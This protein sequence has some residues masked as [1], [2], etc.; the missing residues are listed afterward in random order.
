M[1]YKIV[2][3]F[4]E[5]KLKKNAFK[6]LNEFKE[7]W[8]P[9]I[10]FHCYYYNLDISNYS[11]PQADNI[12]YHKLENIEEYSTFVEENKK[13]NGTEDGAVQYTE[14]LDGL[15]AAPE[16][17]AITECAFEN[18]ESWLLWVDPMCLTV[19]DI[20]ISTLNNYFP[21]SVYNV[22]FVYT[23]ET[24]YLM[25]FNLERQTAVDIL[26]D[27]RGSYM[28]G[29]YINYRE[30][31]SAFILSRLVTIYTAHGMVV[32]EF[33][34]ME[35]LLININNKNSV[36][37][38]NSDGN[39]I[40]ELS[41][42][43]TTP[44]ILPSRY[45]QLADT[46]RFYEPKTILETGTWNGGRAIEM[47]LA[48][49]DRNDAIH[50]I[51]YDLF[52]DATTATDKE[53]FNAKPHNTMEAV[54]KRLDEFKEHIKKEKNKEFSYELHKGNVRDTLKKREEP[55]I[56]DFA[57]IGSG[58]SIKTV[59]HEFAMLSN[60]P[61][62]MG[63]HFFTK[64]D[65]EKTP[66]DKYQGM[67]VLFDSIATKKLHEEKTTDDGW[68]TF[69]EKSNVR[70]HVLPS[71]DKVLGGG[72]THLVVF[73]TD[74]SVADIPPE[75]KQVPIVVHPRDSVPKE[76]I[77]NNIVTN[78]TLIDKD[79]WVKKHPAHKNKA[80]IV[81][82]GPYLDYEELEKFIHDNPGCKVLSVKHALP[83]L[84]KNNIIPWGCIVL[85]PRPITGKS[86]H[87]IVRKDLF[88]KTDPSI[89]FFVASMTDPSV[90]K[91][92]IE[93]DTRMWGWHAFTDSLREEDEQ[94]KVIENQQVKLSQELGIPQGA[95]LITGGT[96]AA[97]RGIGMM[98]TMGFRDIHLFGFDCC[99][100]EPSNE[101]KTETTGDLEGGETPKPKYIQVN[102][103]D[104][105]Y[106]TTGELLAMAQDCEKVFNDPGLEGVLSFHGKDTMVADLWKIK[107]KQEIRPQFK[108]YYDV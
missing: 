25:A 23:P 86:T 108:G 65:D 55:F 43:E 53:E 56:A 46:I 21:D 27:W 49:F 30:W 103:T 37:V 87:N 85:D 44:D 75:L 92:L 3:C 79:K 16:V 82:A 12:K 90:T 6:L 29:E 68:T 26:G 45:K 24:S 52:E 78:L 15:S 5:K 22:D 99:R 38:R 83:G 106:W 95:T 61:V 88:E 36:N 105:S 89:N 20:R 72:R 91:H 28:S 63:D 77:R 66:D 34:G 17:F 9:D 107:E 51:G 80:A 32:H 81:S 4:D 59:Q 84:L 71:D 10:E 42:N 104:K 8:E 11:L 54:R 47:A 13:H 97:M 31:T 102:V 39:R 94:G 2:T 50:Y 74:E 73:L 93:K 69:D 35:N 58:N 76:Y 41:D 18:K 19:K 96:C 48:A 60:T 7:N 1:K 62:I 40:I 98:H 14:L 100:D 33:V 70:K 67:K 64:E 101:E 57:L